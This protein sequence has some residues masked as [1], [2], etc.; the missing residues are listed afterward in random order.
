MARK[1][2]SIEVT[3]VDVAQEAGVSYSTVSRV[4]NN[5]SY[6]K[7]DTRE[8][9][10][11]AMTHLGYQANLQAR[12]L[13]GGRS[14]V[15][16]LLVV[17]LATQYMG[18]LIHGIDD[19]LAANQYELMLYTTHRRKTKESVYVNMMARGLADGLL[20]VLPRELDVYLESLRQRDFP[21][22]LIDQLSTDES[23]LSVTATNYQGGYDATK[24]LIEL[25]HRRIGTITGWMDL[26]SARHRL[27]GYEAALADHGIPFDRDLVIEGDFSQ[28]CG[29]NGASQ[30]LDLPTPPT[31]VFAS[32]DISAMG[33]IDAAR[34]RGL[35]VPGDLSVIGFDDIPMSAIFSPQ[36]TT[37][38]QPLQEMGKTA[39]Q[40]LLSLIDRQRE[41][42]ASIVLPTELMHRESTAPPRL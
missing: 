14:H 42:P 1:K 11:Q 38:R 25:G 9:V 15:I 6:V 39:T 19:I 13:A 3:I 40:L 30:F 5:K 41:R 22:V 4:V 7:P 31:A 23:D 33:V 28:G 35:N 2:T 37:M 24:H 29:F 27:E 10:L 12:S 18:E 16:G 26:I 32:N 36:L 20:I 8:K 21:Y 34:S 17:D